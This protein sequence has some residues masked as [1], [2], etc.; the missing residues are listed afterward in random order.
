MNISKSGSGSGSVVSRDGGIDCG[1]DCE[2]DYSDDST[3]SLAATPDAGSV[4][5]GWRDDCAGCGQELSCNVTLTEDMSCSAVFEETVPIFTLS[6]SRTGTGNGRIT[7]S[8]SGIDCGTDCEEEYESGSSVSLSAT[9]DA[10]SVFGGWGDD[11]AGCGIDNSCVLSITDS[12]SCT[13]VFDAVPSTP[14]QPAPSEQTVGPCTG[15]CLDS[16][17]MQT[18]DDR[19][20]EVAFN[21]EA[22]VYVVAG[23][24]NSALT[25]IYWVSGNG[26][27]SCSVSATDF[28]MLLDN[29]QSIS[30]EVELPPDVADNGVLFWLVSGTPVTALDWINGAYTLQFYQ[31]P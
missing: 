28:G 10:G 7:G 25:S 17:P 4:F 30:C 2:E 8:P 16:A 27:G 21:Y 31:L 15:E 24:M 11:C 12:M 18:T 9:P 29:E 3:V 20:V 1:T 19:I 13:A 26:D 22:P 5:G 23:F 6:V 14:P